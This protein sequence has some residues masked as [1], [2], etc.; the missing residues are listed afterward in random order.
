MCFRKAMR[1]LPCWD[2]SKQRQLCNCASQKGGMWVIL[3]RVHNFSL[4]VRWRHGRCSGA[5]VLVACALE[6]SRLLATVAP[7]QRSVCL[8]R[9]MP[10]ALRPRQRRVS[11]KPS[12]G[13][14]E[15]GRQLPLPFFLLHNS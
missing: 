5:A 3:C 9:W 8:F 13:H 1:L 14:D 12:Y 2:E 11:T 7:T 6:A 10:K 15:D 4:G